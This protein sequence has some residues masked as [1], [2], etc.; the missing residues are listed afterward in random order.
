MLPE[1]KAESRAAGAIVI[2]FGGSSDERR[3]SVASAQNVS[4]E[5]GGA[6]LWFLSREGAIHDCPPAELAAQTRPFETEFTPRGPARYGSLAEALDIAANRG[7][8][9]FLALHGGEGEDGTLQRDFESRGIA[10]TGSGADA[11]AKAFDKRRAKEIV[12]RSAIRVSREAEVTGTDPEGVRRALVA[13]FDTYGDVILK[14]VAG[15][16]SIGLHRVRESKKVAAVAEEIVKAGNV[17]YLIEPFITGR[18]MTVGV[19]EEGGELRALPPSEVRL[20]SD[21]D[22]DYEGKYLGKGSIEITPAEIPP[23]ATMAC[24]RVAI[25][26]HKALGCAGYSRTDM[27]LTDTGPVYLETNTLPGLT[28]ASFIPQQLAAAGIPFP[29]FLA[30]Q[31]GIARKRAGR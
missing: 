22:F 17:R 6:A 26:S 11:S 13:M 24:Q 28:K 20:A 29:K 1:K 14:P 15:G 3:V 25:L 9:F 21:R 31:L 2:L 18:E 12:A 10:F 7:L 27:I 5:L 4:R 23:E 30:E 19:V 16:S 8:A